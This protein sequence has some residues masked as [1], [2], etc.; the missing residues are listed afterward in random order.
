MDNEN[1][2]KNPNKLISYSDPHKIREL[3][4]KKNFSSINELKLNIEAS[5]IKKINPIDNLISMGV[6]RTKI[7]AHPYQMNVALTVLKDMNVNAI[8]ADEV[9]LGKTI[10]A[11]M[12]IKE[13]I[14][15]DR[16]KSVLIICPKALL[17]QW[18]DEL[19]E[20]FGENFEIANDK[21]FQGFEFEDKVICS[22]GLVLHRNKQIT[23]RKWDLIIVDEAHLYRNTKSKGRADLLKIP[24]SH[25]LLLTATPINNKLTDL[26]SLVDL[27]YPGL[28]ETENSFKSRYSADEKNRVVRNDTVDELRNKIAQVMCRTRK[29][30]TDIPFTQ[31]FVESRRIDASKEEK[32]F[33]EKTTEYLKDLCNN[34]FN[35]VEDLKIKNP[36]MKDRSSNLQSKAILIF[37]A[38]SIQQ[39]ISSSPRAAI[40]TLTKRYNAHPKERAALKEIIVLA[41]KVKPA[42]LEL[43]KK[44]L[45]EIKGKQSVIFCIRKSTAAELKSVL[46]KEFGR[47]EI[48][49]GDVSSHNKRKEIIDDFKEGKIR[50]LVATDAAAE[51]LNL[52]NCNTLFNYDLHW[53]PMKIEQRIGRVH[54]FGQDKDVTIFNLSVKDT[55]DDYVIHVLFQ[56]IDLFKMTIGGMETILSEIKD[57]VADIEQTIMDIVTRT[58]TKRDVKK[59]LKELSKDLEYSKKKQ[60]LAEKFTKGVLG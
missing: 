2:I 57:D 29:I 30:E 49:S 54:R 28:L 3:I 8:L 44:V 7:D 25:L 47:A 5:E 15:R 40:D 52:Q 4:Q 58:K 39:S 45:K 42:K 46:T 56:K 41:R 43:L 11:G 50:Y 16:I 9:G 20:K 26:F 48:Y 31:R 24:K 23:S 33:I 12:I 60:Q 34:K 22:S 55:I 59:E 37:Q 14:L 51:G 53:N 13:L 1:L 17:N 18:K 10:E 36:L 35:T 32:I 27:V 21:S 19:R 6:L 38:L